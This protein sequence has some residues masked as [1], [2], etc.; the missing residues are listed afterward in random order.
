MKKLT[1]V[2]EKW[3]KLWNNFFWVKIWAPTLIFQ[4]N[5]IEHK[6]AKHVI[7]YDIHKVSNIQYFFLKLGINSKDL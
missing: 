2:D 1:H 5:I 6:N 3:K 7:W 4:K